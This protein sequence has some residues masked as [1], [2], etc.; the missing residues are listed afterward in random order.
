MALEFS[1]PVRNEK[2]IIIFS[3][4]PRPSP[5][6]VHYMMTS[7]LFSPTLKP[8][9][10]FHI[11]RV[12]C[13][14]GKLKMIG[15]Q[16]DTSSSSFLEKNSPTFHYSS[17]GRLPPPLGFKHQVAVGY[18]VGAQLGSMFTRPNSIDSWQSVGLSSL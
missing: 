2:F 5:S 11:V 7:I 9:V 10:K 8:F 15:A 16:I 13:L 1:F 12:F 3:L 6:P 14:V 4:P 17:A 18:T